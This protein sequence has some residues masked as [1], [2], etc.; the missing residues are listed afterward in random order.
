MSQYILRP[1]EDENEMKIMIFVHMALKGWNLLLIT[2][3]LY[4]SV[5]PRPI[6]M[7]MKLMLQNKQ[8]TKRPFYTAVVLVRCRTNDKQETMITSFSLVIS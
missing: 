7:S 6:Y 8:E 5:L 3:A 4:I 2:V 1:L